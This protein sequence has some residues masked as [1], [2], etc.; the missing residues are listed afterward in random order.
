MKRLAVKRFTILLIVSWFLYTPIIHAEINDDETTNPGVS[1]FLDGRLKEAEQY[2]LSMLDTPKQK[3]TALLYLSR[4]YMHE[5]EFKQATETIAQALEIEPNSVD[6]VLL[7]GDVYCN[8]AQNASMF[9]ALKMAKRCIAQYESAITLSPNNIQALASA[10]EFHLEAPAIAGGSKDKAQQFLKQLHG[11]SP[12]DA[13]YYE[14]QIFARD[15]KTEAALK[16]ADTLSDRGID[17]ARIQ[18]KVGRFYKDAGKFDKAKALLKALSERP[19]SPEDSWFITDSLLQLGETYLHEGKDFQRSIDLI[20]KYRS[21]NSDPSDV[22]YFWATWSL[23][24]AYYAKGDRKKYDALVRQIKSE[25]YKT[26]KPFA[27]TFKVELKEH[28]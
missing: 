17:S 4:I 18:Y 12:E 7:A 19:D 16:L 22:H 1:A 10:V 15:K 26:N 20:E 6:E 24:K 27:D 25:D 3:N 8:R 2:F 5:G 23:A 9:T 14:M 21:L 28:R 11:V 13:M